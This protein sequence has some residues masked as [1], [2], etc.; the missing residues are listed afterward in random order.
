MTDLERLVVR[1]GDALDDAGLPYMLIGGQAVLIHGIPRLIEDIDITL[2]IG[3][4]ELQAIQGV[5]EAEGLE[6]LPEDPA[7]FVR[8]TYVLP[9]ADPGTGIRI[10]FIFSSIPY[11]REA[12]ERSIEVDLGGSSVSVASAEDLILHKLFAGRPRDIEDARGVADIK[13]QDLDWD[14]LARWA[15]EFAEIPGRED[16]P[17][18]FQAIKPD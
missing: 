16:L 9:A 7:E 17:T 15:E 12:I 14:Y 10:G 1:V 3:V 4:D 5:C 8:E 11:E 2:G 13:Q 6:A 18:H